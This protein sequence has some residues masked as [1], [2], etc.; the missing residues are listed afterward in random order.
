MQHGAQ[1]LLWQSLS[2]P[3]VQHKD[4]SI[5]RAR[6]HLV[7]ARVPT[8]LHIKGYIK[9]RLVNSK[10]VNSKNIYF[11]FF[12]NNFNIDEWYYDDTCKPLTGG[13]NA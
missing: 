8:H 9:V 11:Q 1:G 10:T 6:A 13:R 3:Q 5:G 7:T 4:R 12:G 2:L